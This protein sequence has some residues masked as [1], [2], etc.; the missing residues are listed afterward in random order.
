MEE[1]HEFATVAIMRMFDWKTFCFD[2]IPENEKEQALEILQQTIG[3]D[4]WKLRI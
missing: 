4:K 2:H 1:V 3:S